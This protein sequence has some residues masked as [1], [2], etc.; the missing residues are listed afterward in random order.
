MKKLIPLLLMLSAQPAAAMQVT[1]MI[2]EEYKGVQ[3]S[4]YHGECQDDDFTVQRVSRNYQ[5][6][7]PGGTG[8]ARTPEEAI[9]RA[10]GKSSKAK[11]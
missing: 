6:I 4:V 7:G 3:L 8:L 9:A 11:L 5:Y 10:C 1:E 2:M